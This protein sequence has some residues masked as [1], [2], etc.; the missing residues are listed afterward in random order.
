MFGFWATTQCPP[1]CKEQQS[2]RSRTDILIS[3][4]TPP[5]LYLLSKTSWASVFLRNVFHSHP[6]NEMFIVNGKSHCCNDTYWR[7]DQIAA[8]KEYLIRMQRPTKLKISPWYFDQC[9]YPTETLSSLKNISSKRFSTYFFTHIHFMR[10][11]S[12]IACGQWSLL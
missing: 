7:P 5:R 6:F 10:R 11:L 12:S 2:W 1:H 8:S 3:V 9:L 4:F